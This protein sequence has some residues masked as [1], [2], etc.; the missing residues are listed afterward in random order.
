MNHNPNP[1]CTTL[2][3]VVGLTPVGV[4]PLNRNFNEL[5]KETP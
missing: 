3:T 2:A 4:T 5:M 1:M